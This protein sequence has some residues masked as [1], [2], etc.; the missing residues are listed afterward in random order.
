MRIYAKK[1]IHIFISCFE[2]LK[3]VIELDKVK[4]NSPL[5]VEL[6]LYWVR[7]SLVEV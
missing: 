3:K 2:M 7:L 6:K 5:D 1:I 4:R